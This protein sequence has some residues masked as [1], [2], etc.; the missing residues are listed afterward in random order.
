VARKIPK[1]VRLVLS[2]TRQELRKI[3]PDRFKEL[4]LFG[5]YARGDFL[6][7]SDID[8]VLLLENLT[9][10]FRER[11]KYF[12]LIC[13][14]SLENDTVVSVVPFDFDEFQR[15]RTPLIL[16]IKKEGILL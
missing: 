7:G 1:K 3:Y 8:V 15:K 13:R 2:E 9:D 4:I 12:P 16:N 6:D 10:I 5:S 11:E 14:I